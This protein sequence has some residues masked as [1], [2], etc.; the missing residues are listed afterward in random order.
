TARRQTWCNSAI[1]P[2]SPFPKRPKPSRSPLGR[3]GAFGHSPGP[4]CAG[5]WK[6]TG[7]GATIPEFP[8][9]VS[10]GFSH[11]KEE[12]AVLGTRRGC[13]LMTERTIFMA[14][15]EIADPAERATYLERACGGDAALR[16][17]VRRLRA[18]PPREGEVPGVPAGRA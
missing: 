5:R 18:G 2:G 11:C 14:A 10:P 12:P 15:L 8:G 4:G 1:P 6:G 3:P 13:L 7:T 9:Q 16:H 17:P